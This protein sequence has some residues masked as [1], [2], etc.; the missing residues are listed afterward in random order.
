MPRQLV[1]IPKPAA[2]IPKLLRRD[3]SAT[4]PAA[5]SRRTQALA[6]RGLGRAKAARAPAASAGSA[7]SRAAHGSCVFLSSDR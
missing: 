2:L 4:A 6:R 1:R 3:Y 7:A 5:R